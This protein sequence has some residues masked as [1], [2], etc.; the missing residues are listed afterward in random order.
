MFS[1]IAFQE[2]KRRFSVFCGQQKTISK[3]KITCCGYPQLI[4]LSLNSQSIV[5]FVSIALKYNFSLLYFLQSLAKHRT[6]EHLLSGCASVQRR[7]ISH[8]LE[9]TKYHFR[10]R[11]RL[12]DRKNLLF[13]LF[14]KHSVV[15]ETIR[16]AEISLAHIS[17]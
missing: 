2:Q 11:I 16:L 10:L 1:I 3:F 8:S 6:S 4:L 9:I 17:R 7:R 5:S 12:N 15:R 14:R 13:S